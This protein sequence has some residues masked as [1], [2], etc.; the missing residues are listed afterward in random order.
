M[1]GRWVIRGGSVRR[2]TGRVADRPGARAANARRA[3]TERRGVRLQLV[4]ADGRIG[5]GEASPLDGYSPDTVEQCERALEAALARLPVRVDSIPAALAELGVDRAVPAARFAVETAVFDLVGQ[6]TDEPLSQLLARVDPIGG[7]AIARDV[8]LAALVTGTSPADVLAGV[9]AAWNQGIRTVKLKI[10]RPR[11]FAAECELL[12]QLRA[13]FGFDL[14]LRLDA[15]AAWNPDEAADRLAALAPFAP[16]FVEQP[17]AP[18]R[19]DQLRDPPVAIAADES[20]HAA[21]TTAEDVFRSEACHVAVLKPTVIGGLL[22]CRRLAR[23]AAEH[24]VDTVVSHTF[25]GP[26]ALAAAA[27]LALSLPETRAAG[28]APHAGLGAWPRVRIPQLRPNRV[29]PH[30]GGG[31]GVPPVESGR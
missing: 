26:I 11:A 27:E 24:G 5:Q 23:L 21:H 13:Q 4:D 7:G 25:D 30:A 22:A 15:N 20:L 19:I 12:A 28:L 3:W 17:V 8:P 9:R 1:D 10:G 29:V 18:D 16:E 6:R 14:A 31:L 2:V